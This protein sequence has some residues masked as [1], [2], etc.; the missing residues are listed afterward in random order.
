MTSDVFLIGFKRLVFL[1]DEMVKQSGNS[2]DFD[3]EVWV[4]EWLQRPLPALSGKMPAEY[5]YTI[6]GQDLLC[7]LLFMAQSGVYA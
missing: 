6:F 7:K 4:G 2:F 3:A 1:V 5:M